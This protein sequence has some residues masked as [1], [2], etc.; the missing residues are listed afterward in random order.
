MMR[1]A[2]IPP[3][4]ASGGLAVVAADGLPAA[5]LHPGRLPP[6]PVVSTAEGLPV[7]SGVPVVCPGLAFVFVPGVP[8]FDGKVVD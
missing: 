6:T 7:V 3:A 1:G 2:R 5:G 8:V 4:V